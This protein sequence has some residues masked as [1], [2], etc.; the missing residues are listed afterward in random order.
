MLALQQ[1]IDVRT[2]RPATKVAAEPVGPPRRHA[3]S[4][5]RVT[6]YDF[7]LDAERSVALFLLSGGYDIIGRRVR[8]RSGEV[9][10]IAT[11][12]GDVAFVEVK[13]RR[14]GW[15]GLLAVDERKQRRLSRAA[16][17]WLS[18][19]DAFAAFTIRFDIALVWSGSRI[20]YI[21]NAF[22]FVPTDDFVW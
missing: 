6:A 19:N 16:D 11:R 14:K 20:E 9:D 1:K 13:A 21:D 22:D 12:D 15:D 17:E 2:R 5:K 18:R 7:G 3:P 4:R 10:I 8:L